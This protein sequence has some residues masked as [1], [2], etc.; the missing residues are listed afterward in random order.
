[1][2]TTIYKLM[3]KMIA[4]RISPILGTIVMPHQDGFIKGRS[5]YDNIL[6]AMV[7]MEYAQFTKQECILLQLDL[8]KAYDRITWSFVSEVLQKFG[9]GPR[10]CKAIYTMG[11]GSS[12]A[13]LFNTVVVGN[14]KS[15]GQFAKAV[16]LLRF[17]LRH[18]RTR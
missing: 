3:A 16:H 4:T 1:M 9:F 7:G 8:D 10:M 15:S 2:L 6:A 18:A 14:S 5:I 12:S 13:V 17:Y 11:E